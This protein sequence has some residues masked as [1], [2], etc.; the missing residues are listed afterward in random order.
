MPRRRRTTIES[1]SPTTRHA[2]AW[3]AVENVHATAQAD[4]TCCEP[5]SCEGTRGL[6]EA[7]AGLLRIRSLPVSRET[8]T[9]E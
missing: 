7:L 1:G 8:S 4:A 3:F 2:A 6:S 5:M 9:T